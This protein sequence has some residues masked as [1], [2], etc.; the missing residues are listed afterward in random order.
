MALTP[1]YNPEKEA[2]F[3]Q[4]DV[5]LGALLRLEGYTGTGFGSVVVH[6]SDMQAQGLEPVGNIQRNKGRSPV[7]QL[8][9]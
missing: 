4:L 5:V 9:R 1:C 3:K 2:L 7:T 6:L 8:N